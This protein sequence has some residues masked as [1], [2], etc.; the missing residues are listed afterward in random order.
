MKLAEKFK[1]PGFW[2]K[3][4]AVAAICGIFAFVTGLLSQWAAAPGERVSIYWGMYEYTKKVDKYYEIG[5]SIDTNAPGKLNELDSVSAADSIESGEKEVS[6]ESSLVDSLPS[7][8]LVEVDATKV[9][10]ESNIPDAISSR[11]P[12]DVD[13]TKGS[14]ESNVPDSLRSRELV[15]VDEKE[16]TR[17]T[18]EDAPPLTLIQYP[19]ISPGNLDSLLESIRQK[20]QL[21]E[22]TVQESDRK[23][24]ELPSGTYFFTWGLAITHI[25]AVGKQHSVNDNKMRFEG[26]GCQR[27]R[28][29]EI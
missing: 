14:R 24:G 7:R 1:L 13:E 9:S 25:K 10:R 19:D 26:L 16:E 15:E 27:Y 5:K 20:H 11:E 4:S 12:V 29:G 3:V 22:L 6:Q 21:R 2:N 17:G 23:L 28:G 8:E 18:Y